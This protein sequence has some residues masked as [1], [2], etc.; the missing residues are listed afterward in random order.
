M[1]LVPLSGDAL[2]ALANG[3]LDLAGS[4][5]SVVL[6]PY[7]VSPE[8]RSVWK[9]RSEQIEAAPADAEWITRLIVDPAAELAVGR[10]GY[11]GPPDAAGMIEVGYSVDPDHRRKGYARAAL[12]ILLDT[13][14][15][16]PTVRTVRATITPDN[17]PSRSLVDQYGFIEVGEQWDEEDGLELVLELEVGDA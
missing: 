11:H 1:R 2:R 10:A 13:A 5:T 16:L 17:A 4:L 3:D 8:C 12:V 14:R 15:A 6:T 7:L 9:R